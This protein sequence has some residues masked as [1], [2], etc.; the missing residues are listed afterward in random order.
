MAKIVGIDWDSQPLGKVPDEEIAL[1]VGRS[2][3]QVANQ[4]RSRGIPFL[5]PDSIDWD[6]QPFGEVPDLEIAKRV[7]RSESSVGRQRRK[8]GISSWVDR[9][10]KNKVDYEDLPLGKFSDSVVAKLVG[11]TESAVAA[12]R[13]KRGIPSFLS[14]KIIDWDSQ[15]IGKISDRALAILLG[16]S[17]SRAALARYER[18]IDNYREERVCLCG[19]KFTPLR[20][21][22]ALYCSEECREAS[23]KYKTESEEVRRGMQ[24][25]VLGMR[26]F[27]RTLKG[28]ING[29]EINK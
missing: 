1:K 17:H 15:P 25:L 3:K 8:R 14:S 4:R 2:V 18:E 27:R 20:N 19:I 11:V 13:R 6:S 28:K 16:V 26:K 23:K 12:Q 5:K 22:V 7:G 29:V 10:F 24:N 9:G 21:Q